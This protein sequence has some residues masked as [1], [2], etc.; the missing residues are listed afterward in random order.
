MSF[1]CYLSMCVNVLLPFSEA[2][3]ASHTYFRVVIYVYVRTSLLSKKGEN[4]K[5]NLVFSITNFMQIQKKKIWELVQPHLQTDDSGFATLGK[6]AMQTSEGAIV[7][8]S[9][10]NARIS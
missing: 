1:S 6:Y 5:S 4:V 8:K 7:S 2:C 9:L 3:D 10:K